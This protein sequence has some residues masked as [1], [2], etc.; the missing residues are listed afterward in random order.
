[1]LNIAI[2]QATAQQAIQPA[3]CF[4][5]ACTILI[6]RVG[7]ADTELEPLARSNVPVALVYGSEDVAYPPEYFTTFGD[8]LARNGLNVRTHKIDGAPHLASATHYEQ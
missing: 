5:A 6:D 2:A 1:M 3:G 8:Q 7:Y 4:H